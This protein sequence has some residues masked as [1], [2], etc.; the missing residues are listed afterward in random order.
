MIS[1]DNG[2]YYWRSRGNVELILVSSSAYTTYFVLNGSG[3]IR[4]INTNSKDAAALSSETKAK[5]DYVEHLLLGLRSV[6]YYGIAR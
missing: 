3:M 1:V 5:F 6:T 2:H 4:V